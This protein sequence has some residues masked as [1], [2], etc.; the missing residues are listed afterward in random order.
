MASLLAPGA[1]IRKQTANLWDWCRLALCR[2]FPWLT[3]AFLLVCL[4]V[5]AENS[6]LPASLGHLH[7]S[8]HPKS[9]SSAKPSG[10]MSLVSFPT[11]LHPPLYPWS[12]FYKDDNPLHIALP[13]DKNHI[14]ACSTEEISAKLEVHSQPMISRK[15][16]FCVIGTY[17][18]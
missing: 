13:S 1:S 12:P 11:H 9:S 4:G 6:G 7:P 16:K 3:T 2:S 18:A 14:P 17:N 8:C 5:Q 10:S 15:A